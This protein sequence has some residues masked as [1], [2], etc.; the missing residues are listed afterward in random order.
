MNIYK[1]GLNNEKKHL[2]SQLNNRE[3]A[4]FQ[5]EEENI[6]AKAYR[7]AFWATLGIF[8]FGAVIVLLP[9]YLFDDRK[10][11]PSPDRIVSAVLIL[12]MLMPLFYLFKAYPTAKLEEEIKVLKKLLVIKG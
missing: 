6:K 8:I 1:A 4:L 11:E 9:I 3:L 12:L 7:R 10:V 2:L 5:Q